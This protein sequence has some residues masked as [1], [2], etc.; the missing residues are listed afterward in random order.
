VTPSKD[1]SER[2]VRL[3]RLLDGLE[4]SRRG[5]S[6]G[7]GAAATHMAAADRLRETMALLEARSADRLIDQADAIAMRALLEQ[8]RSMIADLRRHT[9]ELHGV[10][11]RVRT[12]LDTGAADV[13]RLE[14]LG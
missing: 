13:Q 8:L 7:S 1:L 10:I 4:Q 11:E 12:S 2:I 3:E 5:G 14:D 6:A 9:G